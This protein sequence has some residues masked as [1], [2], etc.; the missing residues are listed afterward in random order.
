MVF[1]GNSFFLGQKCMRTTPSSISHIVKI[2]LQNGMFD[3]V[4]IGKDTNTTYTTD[5][6]PTWDYNTLLHAFFN[7]NLYAGNVD[8]QLSQVS[9]IRIKRRVTGEYEY[10]TLF[11]IPIK[12]E[13]DLRFTRYDRLAQSGIQYDYISVPVLNNV[14]GN[15]SVKSVLSQF[16]G[17][18]IVGKDQTFNTI[19]NVAITSQKNRPSSIINTIDRKYPYVVS[20]GLNNYYSGT[21]TG[22]FLE[23][24]TDNFTWKYYDGWKHRADLMDFLCD[25]KPKILKHYDGRIWMISVVEN[26]TETVQEQNDIVITSFNWTESDDYNSTNA[27]YN[28][29]F[30]EVNV[31]GR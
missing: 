13:S 10:T 7:G 29:G 16:E 17:V 19:L 21:T 20:N 8:F 31:E 1:L 5:I 25:G 30:I 14:E 9:S 24:E 3:E 12:V 23:T 11:E 6:N 26:P 4:Y 28:G 18:F 15:S 22:M 27:L 2:K